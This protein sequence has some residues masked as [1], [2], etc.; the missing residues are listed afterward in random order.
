MPKVLA[1]TTDGRM[2]YCSC[3]PDK[4][5]LGRCNHAIHQNEGE[6]IPD[7][8]A[9]IS[10]LISVTGDEDKTNEERITEIVQN[11]AL[12]F[13]KNP[14]WN[15]TV[16][17]MISRYLR[18]GDKVAEGTCEQEV[19][20]NEFGDEVD[21]LTLNVTFDGEQYRV[22]FGDVPHV[23]DNGTISINGIEY[24][25]LPVVSRNKVGYGQGYSDGKPMIW[26]Y[27]EDGN[28][29]I[30]IPV[31]GDKCKILGKWYNKSE[32]EEAIANPPHKDPK[33]ALMLSTVDHR[34]FN[35]FPNWGKPG[36]MDELSKN[37]SPD[38][39]N[40]LE[41]RRVYTYEDQVAKELELQM[42]RMGVTLR[43][44]AMKGKPMIM[45]KNNTANVKTMLSGRS[46]VQAAENLNPLAAYSQAHKVS[47]VGIEGYN[48]DTCPDQLR[49]PGDSY[50]GI[51]DPLD[52]SSGKGVGL[53]V[54]LKNSDV[55]DGSIVPIAGK[56]D[57]SLTDFVPYMNHNNPNRVSMATS[58]MRQAMPLVGGEDPRIL[59]D[60]TS[61]RAWSQI[62]GAGIGR[63]LK[64]V[65][66]A[67]EKEWEDSAEISESAAKKMSAIK[68]FTF[69]NDP[70]FSDGQSVKAGTRIAGKEVKYD[71]VLEKTKT[72]FKI[73]AVVPFT[74]GNKIAGR[75]GNKC[76]VGRIVPDDQMPKV[77]N[78]ATKQYEPAEVIMSPLS[79]GK[80]GN[81]GAIMETQDGSF[82]EK[83]IVDVKL[84]DGRTVHANN[85]TQFIMRL[86]QI[87]QEKNHAH[88]GTL[89]K[90]REASARFGE[91][92]S[93]LMTTTEK[94]RRV[95]NFLKNQGTN[96][97]ARIESLLKAIGITRV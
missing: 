19:C 56:N 40:D 96:E 7:F 4:R 39:I 73:N 93:I 48:K 6:S 69:G 13:N 59:G 26:I 9:R 24:R 37:F 54:F 44:T 65:Y 17:S 80:R 23:K 16:S 21:R 86:N 94:R 10:N 84:P 14:N 51:S 77:Y 70:K 42:R 11:N 35:R 60:E 30:S 3:P 79:I 28:L 32:I 75:Y 15:N 38:K 2:T 88:D 31:E 5:G 81:I 49:I 50:R 67:G 1:L 43:D 58:Q 63:N 89:G 29:A 12:S 45:Q 91:M 18:L 55:I 82:S 64:T 72:G 27:Q 47:L 71:G 25:C 61:D 62:S 76:T 53:N 57:V 36:S 33:V 85:G 87:S 74:T 97:E 95:L 20:I 90:D 8:M 34:I 22:D 52:Q 68:T 92:E 46:N 66:L 83:D 41:W 78:P